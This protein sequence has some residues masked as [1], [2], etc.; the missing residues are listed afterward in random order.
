[1]D[2]GLLKKYTRDLNVLLI[3]D[4][5]E[6]R[7]ELKELLLDIFPKVESAVD[8]LDGIERYKE[9]Y[10]SSNKFYDLVISDIKMPNVNGI[11]LVKSIYEIHREQIV[12]VLSA[13]NEFNY[14]LPLINLKIEHFFTK[15]INYSVFM[16]N[17]FKICH[18]LYNKPIKE[19]NLIKIDDQTFWNK[20]TKELNNESNIVDLTKKEMIFI[21]TLLKVHGRILTTDEL[22]LAIWSDNYDEKADIR[23]LKNLISRI[24]KK[25]PNL[26]IKNIYGMGYK[27]DFSAINQGKMPYII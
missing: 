17:I 1:M 7:K 16:E 25:V 6:F 23:N 22:I 11:D 2:Y 9:Y 10:N 19:S 18:V 8:G 13:R 14:L 5:Q 26:H 27:A 12:L 24:R 3:E 15:P 4:D 20:K 21:D